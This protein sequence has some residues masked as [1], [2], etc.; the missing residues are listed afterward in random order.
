[1]IIDRKE[2]IF[3]LSFSGFEELKEAFKDINDEI[4]YKA[5]KSVFSKQSREVRDHAKR[6]L[7]VHGRIDTGRLQRVIRARK[8]RTRS[9][10]FWKYR[11]GVPLGESRE[12]EK[13][14][15]YAP[16]IEFGTSRIEEKSYLRQGL[17]DKSPEI[18]SEITNN[19]RKAI[20]KAVKKSNKKI[21]VTI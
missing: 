9:I 17:E 6:L 19:V 10:N 3:E 14:A 13:G 16:F 7:E 5:V 21:K 1:M 15:F 20:E 12:D 11:I 2:K 18:V 8:V 4:K